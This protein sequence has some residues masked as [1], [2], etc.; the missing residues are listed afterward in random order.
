MNKSAR[1]G[2][3]MLLTTEQKSY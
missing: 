3:G 1:N 2:G